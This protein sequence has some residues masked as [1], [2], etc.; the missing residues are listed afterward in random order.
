M[1]QNL[2]ISQKEMNVNLQQKNYDS[3]E[4]EKNESLVEK[5]DDFERELNK[6]IKSRKKEERRDLYRNSIHKKER[7]DE[8]AKE[9]T[10]STELEK[11]PT[12]QE[13]EFEQS[14]TK[15]ESE[16]SCEKNIEEQDSDTDLDNARLKK[17]NLNKVTQTKGA[18]V[19]ETDNTEKSKPID[20]GKKILLYNTSQLSDS[21]N[22][23]TDKDNAISFNKNGE[24]NYAKRN[25]LIKSTE[26]NIKNSDERNGKSL[27]LRSH[28]DL[29]DS[30]K[31]DNNLEN[32]KIS[33]H[34]KNMADGGNRFSEKLTNESTHHG[35]H[36]MVN[37][38]NDGTQ[39]ELG[40]AI[41]DNKNKSI[42]N[43]ANTKTEL[44]FAKSDN[45]GM[46]LNNPTNE[47]G[48]ESLSTLKAENNTL[49]SLPDQSME[50]IIKNILYSVKNNQA[51]VK[52]DLRPEI[53]GHMRVQIV[54]KDNKI[55]IS[56]ATETQYVKEIIENSLSR[57]KT[58]FINSK[59]DI[60]K[61]DVFI[62]NESFKDNEN[63]N[64]FKNRKIDFNEEKLSKMEP[65]V[66]N[67]SRGENISLHVT[68]ATS[69]IDYYV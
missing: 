6:S 62:G 22:K 7:D 42:K 38:I 48:S 34:F 33:K 45:I 1:S 36:L 29:I 37:N 31:Q 17:H 50:K 58:E 55:K 9:K 15:P 5:R 44:S 14:G 35:K 63:K 32:E 51:E 59:L 57:L 64:E 25:S 54:S 8:I 66:L 40:R 10:I 11:E 19:I 28:Q 27:D 13:G 68:D 56:I 41:E 39:D 47:L 46:G 69:R 12:K 60:D 2:L 18:E 4:K 24:S 3:N 65:P 61:L 67:E 16:D 23:L 43:L 21:Q 26:D 20:L 52:I 30:P 53:L 49:K